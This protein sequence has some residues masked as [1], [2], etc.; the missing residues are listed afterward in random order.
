MAVTILFYTGLSA[1][2]TSCSF[3]F[4]AIFYVTDTLYKRKER[5]RSQ[6]V[7]VDAWLS[8]AVR[9]GDYADVYANVSNRSEGTVRL[10]FF[11]L[12]DNYAVR[13]C[14]P[15][16]TQIV[17]PTL[18]G[19]PLDFLAGRVLLPQELKSWA[20]RDLLGFFKFELRFGDSTGIT[21][22]R[23]Y[24]GRLQEVTSGSVP[25]LVV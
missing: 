14:N 12:L 15:H 19:E 20:D 24:E 2:A 6:A 25:T 23:N 18:V 10:V 1:I 13:M 21:W 16:F 22:R 8:R 7:L 9:D 11:D 3:A 5:R 17:P 4:A